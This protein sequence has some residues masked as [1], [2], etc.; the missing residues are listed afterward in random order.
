MADN[1]LPKTR[2]LAGRPPFATGDDEH[3]W[4]LPAPRRPP[5][6]QEPPNTHRDSTYDAYDRYLNPGD[7]DESKRDSGAAFGVGMGLMGDIS[8]DSDSEDDDFR[9]LSAT[10][11]KNRALYEAA[12]KTQS[13]PLA[14]TQV[15]NVQLADPTGKTRKAPGPG[16]PPPVQ[17]LPS[18][19]HRK[20][21][22]AGEN[23][24]PSPSTPAPPYTLRG[25][26]RK[27]EPGP[28]IRIDVPP[29]SVTLDQSYSPP[30][31]PPARPIDPNRARSPM[32][33]PIPQPAR[34]VPAFMIPSS[35][36]PSIGSGGSYSPTPG[37]VALPMSPVTPHPLPPST[38]IT[39]LFAAPPSALS[40][41]ISVK[42]QEK[43]SLPIMRGNS[44]DA[45]LER[46]PNTGGKG[47][48][49]DDFWRRFSMVAHEAEVNANRKEPS[50]TW[51]ARTQAKTRTMSRWVWV[52]G[53]IVFCA[54]AAGIGFGVYFGHKR[55]A[56]TD[57]VAFGGKEDNS[58][59]PT[60]TSISTKRKG[61]SHTSTTAGRGG[62]PVPRSIVNEPFA[63]TTGLSQ[64][65]PAAVSVR[66]RHHHHPN[67]RLHQ[68]PR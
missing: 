22:P 43:D 32:P 29:V 50:S 6:P 64:M 65:A 23:S 9:K 12:T 14:L 21:Q 3:I 57:P 11:G 59:V 33:A 17:T 35:P 24:T 46:S 41:P 60:L 62:T 47:K 42:F 44:E 37:R 18:E 68:G 8:D 20:L 67:H 7:G 49:G 15:G 38:P 36:A 56:H 63:V 30:P 39:P 5:Q 25:M 31:P 66:R 48:T 27:P 26:P 2:P 16:N 54:A 52:I 40:T 10:N 45:L 4:D 53:I 1:A 13:Q 51:L 58:M 55:P 34:P 28:G 19:P 61:P